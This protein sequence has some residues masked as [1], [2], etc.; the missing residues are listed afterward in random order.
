MPFYAMF[1]SEGNACVDRI[2]RG[3]A[4]LPL[5]TTNDQLYSFLTSEM[6]ACPHK[7]IWDTEVRERMIG[8]LERLTNRSLSIYF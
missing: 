4:S 6:N 8:E 2:V 7:E 5:T 1:S 3:A